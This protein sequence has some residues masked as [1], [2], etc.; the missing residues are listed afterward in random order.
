MSLI[1]PIPNPGYI[2]S[3]YYRESLYK[4]CFLGFLTLLALLIE[5]IFYEGLF[6][7]IEVELAAATCDSTTETCNFFGA[8]LLQNSAIN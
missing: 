7:A 6:D 1:K 4:S 5:S 2:Y 8:V 3:D